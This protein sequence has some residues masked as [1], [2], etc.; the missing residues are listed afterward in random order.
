MTHWEN[1]EKLL[2]PAPYYNNLCFAMD[3]CSV[4]LLQSD[5]KEKCVALHESLSLSKLHLT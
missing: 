5:Q 4:T 1:D 2:K 3:I